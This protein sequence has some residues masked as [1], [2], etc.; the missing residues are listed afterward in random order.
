L[1]LTTVAACAPVI[2]QIRPFDDAVAV[3]AA[4]AGQ[5]VFQVQWPGHHGGQVGHR[6][7]RQHRAAHVGV[8]H[9]AGEV[10]HGPQA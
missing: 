6:D 10:D 3:A 8:D 5:V 7:L 9:R 4:A 2:S 1:L